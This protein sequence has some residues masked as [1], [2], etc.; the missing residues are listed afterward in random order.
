MNV[1]IYGAG[2]VGLGLAS[3]LIRSGEEVALVGRESTVQALRQ[4]GLHRFG[5]FGEFRTDPG[6]FQAVPSLKDLLP[7]PYDFILVC[8]KTF[9]TASAAR[10]L[11]ACPFLFSSPARL[12][13]CQNGWGSADLCRR[14]FPPNRVYHARVITG[15]QRPAPHQVEITV[16]ADAVHLG[17][18][19]GEDPTVLS[20][21]A[22][23]LTRGGL[24]CRV[25]PDIAKDLWAKMVY[26]CA[27]N[28]LGAILEV[29]YGRLGES[30]HTRALMDET[31][32]EVFQVMEVS[33]WA[34]HWHRTED[35]LETF[36]KKLLPATYAHESSMLQDLRAG[37]KTEID[38]LNGTV[39]QL[40]ARAGLDV[41]INAALVRLI[42]FKEERG[43]PGPGTPGS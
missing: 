39:V 34:T 27:L 35:F 9:D 17:S 20:P 7:S 13:I 5:L 24:P 23:S 19:F 36:Y 2:S 10:D 15:F 26:N 3:C 41:P 4:E 11:A 33:G 30:E 12:V 16:H 43:K 18:I 29:P 37:K 8:T 25:S 6:S 28:A 38:F 40:G 31:V 42:R 14:F 22:D 1:L 32:G 21:L